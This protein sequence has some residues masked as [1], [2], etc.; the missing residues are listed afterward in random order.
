MNPLELLTNPMKK[1][2][3]FR[4]LESKFVGIH[5]SLGHCRHIQRE[6]AFQYGSQSY[7]GVPKAHQKIHV[8]HWPQVGGKPTCTRQELQKNNRI[9]INAHET[10]SLANILLFHLH[11]FTC[12]W[13][14]TY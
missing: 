3:I 9:F 12:K 2:S 11:F 5:A 1:T 7:E 6:S 13:P 8:H 10:K 4:N 14:T